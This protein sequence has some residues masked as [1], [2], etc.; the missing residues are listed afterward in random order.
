MNKQLSEQLINL[1]LNQV[2]SALRY[3]TLSLNTIKI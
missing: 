2:F 3:K 1:R